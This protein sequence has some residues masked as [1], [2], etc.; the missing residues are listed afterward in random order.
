MATDDNLFPINP[1]QNIKRLWSW[2]KSLTPLT[3]VNDMLWISPIKPPSI[4]TGGFV[5]SVGY[6]AQSHEA[7]WG[8][9]GIFT[10]IETDFGSL[11]KNFYFQEHWTYKVINQ[12]DKYFEIKN[13]NKILSSFF[14]QFYSLSCNY[15]SWHMIKWWGFW[16][17]SWYFQ[18]LLFFSIASLPKDMH[19]QGLFEGLLNG[20]PFLPLNV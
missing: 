16:G 18:V 6:A 1:T 17:S 14:W 2:L 15:S 13:F 9:N 10:Q 19:A 4:V 12:F 11:R 8:L 7:K 5:F 3:D 20:V